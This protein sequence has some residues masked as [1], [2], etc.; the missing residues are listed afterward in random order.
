M[1]LFPLFIATSLQVCSTVL[2]YCPGLGQ[3]IQTVYLE[4]SLM[5]PKMK[6]NISADAYNNR[7]HPPVDMA[8]GFP[9]LFNDSPEKR[10]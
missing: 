8:F 7:M 2:R 4:A 6:Q 10:F 1:S 5:P 3:L 9:T